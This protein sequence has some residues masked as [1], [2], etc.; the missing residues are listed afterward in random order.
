MTAGLSNIQANEMTATLVHT[1]GTQWGANTGANT[2]DAEKEHY[3]NDAKD[4]WAGAAYAEFSFSI[5]A[6][7]TVTGAKLTYSV[8]QGGKSGRNDIIYYMAPNFT[9]PYD[10]I[11]TLTGDLRYSSDRAGK[12]VESAPTGGT[13]DRLNLEQDVTDAVKAILNAGQNYII[14]QWTGN[15]GGADLYGKASENAP[16][17]TITTASAAEMTTYTVRFVDKEGTEIKTAAV[18]DAPIGTD[19]T[20]SKDNL[21]PFFNENNTKKYI[22]ESGNS[23]I[24]TGSNAAENIITL[25]F[26]E[27]ANYN[28]TINTSVADKTFEI[29]KGSDFEGETITYNYPR[30]YNIDGTLYTIAKNGGTW[31]QRTFTLTGDNHIET[32]DGYEAT[33][34]TNIVYYSEA[35]DIESLTVAPEQNAGIR[36][37]G[38]KIARNAGPEDAVITTLPAGKYKLTSTVWGGAGTDFIFKAG[39]TTVL[40]IT[41]TGSSI[42]NTGDEFE[43]NNETPIV[44]QATESSS[45]GIDYVYIQKTGDAEVIPSIAE[46]ANIAELKKLDDGTE[47]KLTLTD[48]KITVREQGMRRSLVII[49]DATGAISIESGV[50]ME[51][52]DVFAKAGV[53]LNG[54][55]Y[56]T[57]MNGFGTIGM[58]YSEKTV[59][60]DIT[61][62]EA[63]VEPTVMTVGD[64]LSAENIQ[65]FVKL[66]NVELTFDENAYQYTITQNDASITIMDM[67]Q[68]MDYENIYDKLKFITGISVDGG[69][70]PMFI[71][72]GNPAFEAAND[73]QPVEETRTWDFTKWS[74]ETKANLAAEAAAIPT[75]PYPVDVETGWRTYEKNGGPTE[76]EPDRGGAAYWYGTNI[77]EPTELT[78]NGV[79]IAET[80]GLFIN[81]LNGNNGSMAIAIDYPE[82]ALGTYAGGSYLWFNGKNYSFIIPNVKPGHKI[83]MEVESHKSTDARGMKLTVSGTDIAIGEGIPTAKDSYEWT[84]PADA[85]SKAVDVLVTTTS[86]C[87]IYTIMVG[88]EVS[89]GISNMNDNAT[90]LNGN[91]YSINGTMVRKAGDS[92]EGLA[93]GIYVIGG[94][95]VVIK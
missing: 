3:N 16:V 7:E 57:F 26:R 56:G 53:A 39:E 10:D 14:F 40:T 22:Y 11:P 2:V 86:G 71:P 91:V 65:K 61:V 31:Y 4:S 88:E 9:L 27:A 37:S 21:M 1:A 13:G 20:A 72:V 58:D 66:E 60:S 73:P 85:G 84:V 70:Y 78:A 63:V 81:S 25:V 50:L 36:M 79:V 54:T 17:L 46:A 92:L 51:L 95:K 48:A 49:E 68:K 43:L 38:G 89:T 94:K 82:T 30:Y 75:D 18:Y 45:R 19:V 64:I 42:D 76:T 52:P 33:E 44:L 32:V 34:T 80:K 59:N 28:Y 67:F 83:A 29:L 41:T 47:A 93:K 8:N 69:E 77:N 12:A 74:D 23:T 24:K 87:H 6:G 35:E 55:L 15:A 62:T 5:P 90:I